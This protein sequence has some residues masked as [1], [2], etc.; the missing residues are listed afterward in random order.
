MVSAGEHWWIEDLPVSVNEAE[1]RELP[2]ASGTVD[3][4]HGHVLRRRREHPA[5]QSIVRGLASALRSAPP[6]TGANLA[7]KTWTE[8]IL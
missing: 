4:V 1:Y 3:V 8:L 5:E 7:L 6:A 2:E